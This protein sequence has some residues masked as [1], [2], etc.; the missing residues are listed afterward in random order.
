[1]VFSLFFHD[2]ELLLLLFTGHPAGVFEEE[3]YKPC[4]SPA[5]LISVKGT[6]APAHAAWVIF[7][8]LLLFAGL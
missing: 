8:C 7:C 1:M 2:A 6:V 4:Q 3:K 5:K